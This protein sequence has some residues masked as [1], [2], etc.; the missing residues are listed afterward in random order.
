MMDVTRNQYFF[1]GLLCL[2][3]GGELRM[4]DTVDLTPEFT[5]FLAER[6][7]HPVAAVNDVSQSLIQSDRPLVKKTIHMPDWSGWGL[8][9]VGAVLV[10]HS[11]AMKKP[12]T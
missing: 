4:I 6:T 1:A 11:W 3:L 12:G 7:G 8:L 5:Q 9:S 10:L 2:L